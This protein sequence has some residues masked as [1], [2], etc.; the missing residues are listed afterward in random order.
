MVACFIK[1]LANIF[2]ALLYAFIVR[3]SLYWMIAGAIGYACVVPIIAIVPFV[4]WP[5]KGRIARGRKVAVVLVAPLAITVPW[6]TPIPIMME[7]VGRAFISDLTHDAC[8]VA[9]IIDGSIA[10]PM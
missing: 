6:A 7:A 8:L 1:A 3:A 5:Q 4:Y 9:F 10:A 2:V